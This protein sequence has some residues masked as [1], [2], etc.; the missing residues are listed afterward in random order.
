MDE[1][2]QLQPLSSKKSVLDIEKQV[3]RAV[4]SGAKITIG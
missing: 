1:K 3:E 4:A 2:T